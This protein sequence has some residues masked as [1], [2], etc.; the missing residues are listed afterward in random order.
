MTP[1]EE[2]KK[3]I[4]SFYFYSLCV[5]SRLELGKYVFF[6]WI[7]MGRELTIQQKVLKNTVFIYAVFC[8]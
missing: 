6:H 1:N 4:H 2:K 7:N 8:K 5:I 3:K